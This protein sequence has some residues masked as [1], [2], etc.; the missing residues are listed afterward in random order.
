VEILKLILIILTRLYFDPDHEKDSD[1]PLRGNKMIKKTL[2]TIA[3]SLV[4]ILF[5][6]LTL[7]DSTNITPVDSTGITLTDSEEMTIKDVISNPRYYNGKN[8]TIEGRVE[9][10]H[11]M[12]YFSGDPY[13]LFRLR[14]DERNKIGVYSKGNLSISEGSKLRVT[15][16]FKKEK[17]NIFIKF[18]NVIKAKQI[19]Q[20][21]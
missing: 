9:K 15:G 11:H 6:S 14:D 2:V 21:V 13:T 19:E 4:I 1:S 5:T 17:G 3:S 10:V 12:T 8:I 16:I 20:I 18:K 7:A